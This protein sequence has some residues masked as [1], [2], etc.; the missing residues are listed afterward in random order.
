MIDE[1]ILS[2]SQKAGPQA[3]ICGLTRYW[4]A[5]Q[6]VMHRYGTDEYHSFQTKVYIALIWLIWALHDHD[7]E[8]TL[9]SY[10]WIEATV[11]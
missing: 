9:G 3:I 7:V 1:L 8:P 5:C 2:S 4:V 6:S 10:L 11:L